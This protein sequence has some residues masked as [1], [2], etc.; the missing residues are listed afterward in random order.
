MYVRPVVSDHL[1]VRGDLRQAEPWRTPWFAASCHA[2]SE[3]P[4]LP[5]R[6]FYVLNKIEN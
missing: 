3:R 1:E 6:K 2:P 5:V 4:P